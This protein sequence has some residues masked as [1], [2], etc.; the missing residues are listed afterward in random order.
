MRSVNF[1][2]KKTALLQE[3]QSS[4]QLLKAELLSHQLQQ[5]FC[6]RPFQLQSLFL[7]VFSKLAV[8]CVVLTALDINDSFHVRF[9]DPEEEAGESAKVNL[10]NPCCIPE[11][12]RESDRLIETASRLFD[13]ENRL[14]R[15]TVSIMSSPFL[16]R[17]LTRYSCSQKMYSLLAAQRAVSVR[18]FCS[19]GADDNSITNS[20]DREN[21]D[22]MF[23]VENLK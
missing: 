8:H 12:R 23:S 5:N 10:A 11:A 17:A 6:Q 7:C 22:E 21:L 14:R 4:V 15:V 3:H 9:Q 1:F 2:I 20:K 16:H 18:R 19:A 13:R